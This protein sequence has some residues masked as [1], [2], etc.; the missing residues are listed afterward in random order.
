MTYFFITSLSRQTALVW[1][2]DKPEYL[3]LSW[4]RFCKENISSFLELEVGE[5]NVET[6]QL[7]NGDIVTLIKGDYE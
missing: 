3:I 6:D 7:F 2:L 5:V 1:V 4:I